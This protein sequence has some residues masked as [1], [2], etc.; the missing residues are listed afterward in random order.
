MKKKKEIHYLSKDD[1]IA[2]DFIVEVQKSQITRLVDVFA[3]G[4]IMI[5]AGSY[6]A[7]PAFIRFALIVIG[8]STIYYNGK[9]FIANEINKNKAKQIEK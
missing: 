1:K 8:V 3:I 6:K 5:Y 7:L 2:L 4:P 9:N